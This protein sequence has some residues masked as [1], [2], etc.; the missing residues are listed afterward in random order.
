MACV[1]SDDADPW[2]RLVVGALTVA[3]FIWAVSLR[4]R[5]A[6]RRVDRRPALVDPTLGLL[7]VCLFHV[8]IVRTRR[9][10]DG[11]RDGLG[12]PADV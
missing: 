5:H 3:A 4:T 10:H 1:R 11:A 9:A 2:G 12:R 8:S 7:L 6:L